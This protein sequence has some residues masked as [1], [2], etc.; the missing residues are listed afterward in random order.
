[1][2]K[3]IIQ[4]RT[5]I[6][7]TFLA[8]LRFR[9]SG[10]ALGFFWFILTPLLETTI[11]AVVFSQLISVRSSGGRDISYVVYLISGLF[12]FMAFSQV[13]NRGSNAIKAN[14]IYV[15]R[16]LIPAEVFVFKEAMLAGFSLFIYLIF[17]VPVSLFAGNTITWFVLLWPVFSILLSLLGFGIAQSL[18]NLRILFPDLG[19]II[20]VLLQLWRWTLPIMFTDKGFPDWL[21]AIMSLNPPYHFIQSFRDILIEHTLPNVQAWILMAFWIIFFLWI[22]QFIAQKLRS[23][24]KDLL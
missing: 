14:A 6:F 18:A 22:S 12:P 9:Y 15:R 2:L 23:E 17:F 4:Y 20:P 24:V 13:I 7:G 21:R 1:M 3:N 11:Y 10:T 19:E 16:S 8:D 5:Y